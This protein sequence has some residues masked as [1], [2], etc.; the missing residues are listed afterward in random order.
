MPDKKT[1]TT[2]QP[3]R[4]GK[5]TSR[6]GQSS[7]PKQ[8]GKPRPQKTNTAAGI[9][10]DSK[11]IDKDTKI[12]MLHYMQLTRAIELYLGGDISKARYEAEKRA[13]EEQIADLRP[14]EIR[15]ILALPLNAVEIIV[16]LEILALA[17]SFA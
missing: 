1:R 12:K 2:G 4:P 14:G 15:D 13:C 16:K 7:A 17:A 8:G 5:V 3:N 9:S 6:R 11:V 10:A